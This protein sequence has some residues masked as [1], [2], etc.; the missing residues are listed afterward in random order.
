M[1]R[2]ND[3]IG[4]KWNQSETSVIYRSK[5]G[6]LHFAGTMQKMYLKLQYPDKEC[7]SSYICRTFLNTIWIYLL[8][9]LALRYSVQIPGISLEAYEPV[10]KSHTT[11]KTSA[12]YVPLY[13]RKK[14]QDALFVSHLCLKCQPYFRA[15]YYTEKW[16]KIL[17]Q[18]LWQ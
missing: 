18:F 10:N 6:R 13:K 15:P 7:T 2:I 11:L 3:V 5:K 14:F 17:L 9:S 8:Y 4:K 16:T 12:L 1:K